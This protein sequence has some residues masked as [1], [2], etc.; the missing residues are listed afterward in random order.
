MPDNY[1]C[2]IAKT[3]TAGA[4]TIFN[5]ISSDLWLSEVN[6]HCFTN[7]AKYGSTNDLTNIY[8][9]VYPNDVISFK[10]VN[11]KDFYFMNLSAGNNATITAVGVTMRDARKKE[12]GIPLTVKV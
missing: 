1:P 10:D 7:G 3:Y 8:G 11:L 2:I 9:T 6:I 12:L 5:L 4:D